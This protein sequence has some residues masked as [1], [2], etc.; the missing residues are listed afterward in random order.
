MPQPA[1]APAAPAAPAGPK[2]HAAPTAEHARIAESPDDG[3]PWRA[4][5]PYVSARQ[6]GTVREDYSANGDAWADFPFDHAHVRAYRWGEDGLAGICDRF[7]FLNLAVA[8]WNRR[9]DRLKERLF[10]LTNGQGN[11]GEDAKE[12]WWHL[13]AT[14]THSYA[15]WL[16]RYPQAAYPYD[17]LL[18]VNAERRRTDPEFELSDTGILAENRFFDVKVTHA[19][20]CL[21]YTSRCV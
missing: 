18:T 6:W 2:A 3:D 15:E 11:H 17:E 12:Y 10:G 21:L 5:G 20:T 7:G 14:P 1:S 13:D 9:D 19:K 16:Y 8:V 4:W